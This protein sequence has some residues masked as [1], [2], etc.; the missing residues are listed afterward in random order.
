MLKYIITLISPFVLPFRSDVCL[1]LVCLTQQV[2]SLYDSSPT[3]KMYKS[4][5]VSQAN[6]LCLLL[7][8]C[9]P[10]VCKSREVTSCYVCL[11]VLSVCVQVTRFLFKS[12]A[13]GSSLLLYIWKFYSQSILFTNS[14]SLLLTK[15][16]PF[17][18]SVLLIEKVFPQSNRQTV[19]FITDIIHK[20]IKNTFY[21]LITYMA[22]FFQIILV[23]F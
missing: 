19:S 4:Q 8:M 22:S 13:Y 17:S 9:C 3:H 1:P 16:I 15:Q 23:Y 2:L 10:Y 12:Q 14:S 7:C 20:I 6:F 5:D 11:Y 18:H 21:I